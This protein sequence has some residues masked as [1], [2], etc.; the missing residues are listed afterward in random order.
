VSSY[1]CCSKNLATKTAKHEKDFK[2]FVLDG[3]TIDPMSAL[4]GKMAFE[5][6]AE[7]TLLRVRVQVET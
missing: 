3:M 4:V 1:R 7:P 6:P 2:G 5:W